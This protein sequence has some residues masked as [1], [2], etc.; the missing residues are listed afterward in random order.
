VTL[1]PGAV[2]GPG[3]TRATPS[4]EVVE[5]IM[6][7][8]LRFGAPRLGLPVI[9]VRD[10]IRGHV[11]AAERDVRGRF[12]LCGDSVPTLRDIARLMREIDR[13]VPRSPMELPDILGPLF[14][15]FD[16]LNARLN[17]SPVTLAP[18]LVEAMLG[19]RF[20]AS[21]ARARAELGWSPE[22]PLRQTLADT[23]QTIRTLRRSAGRKI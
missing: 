12:I 22:I 6:L 5:G 15:Y 9:D 21:N 1:L 17:D 11:L 16:W 23:M 18:E 2:C 20:H 14:P 7:G 19:R 4:T 10:V 3:F 8:A 13:A